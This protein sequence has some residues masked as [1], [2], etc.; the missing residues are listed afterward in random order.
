MSVQEG[1]PATAAQPGARRPGGP[2]LPTFVVIG[3]MK[4]GTTSLH[5]YLGGHPE[6][7]VTATKELHYFVAEKN[8]G[9]G[10][11]WYARQF[12]DAG[13]ARAVGETS[14]DYAKFP[15]HRGVPARMAALVPDVRL[16]YVVR[17]PVDRIRSHYLHDLARGRERRP[18]AEAV[19]GNEHYLAPSRY[20]VQ[21]QQYLDHFASDQL[22]VVRSEDLRADRG[23]TMA[24][25][26][27]FVGVTPRPD[28]PVH[29]QELNAIA[30]KSTPGLAL[31]V[32]RRLPGAS[33][34]R[35]LAPGPVTAAERLL[36]RTRQPVDPRLGAVS[37]ALR[38]R[39]LDELGDTARL[40]PLPGQDDGGASSR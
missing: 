24:R 4:A 36:G 2:T 38:A 34:L 10:P 29:D 17:D 37:A 19:P 15:V 23:A 40:D 1:H 32:G 12:R 8:L 18:L 30:G 16:V 9:R 39:L 6:V 13:D 28:L 20:A 14:P 5:H 31:R 21:V 27:A 26:H 7:F 35:L 33:R 25:V 11:A 22:L 3:A